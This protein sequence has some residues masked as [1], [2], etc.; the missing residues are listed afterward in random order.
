[1]N[2]QERSGV[3]AA[4]RRPNRGPAGAVIREASP[5]E[6]DRA[7]ADTGGE[8]P[9]ESLRESPRQA[10][11]RG[12]IAGIRT[13]TKEA[14]GGLDVRAAENLA[15][16]R[17]RQAGAGTAAPAATLAPAPRPAAQTPS[18]PVSDGL[19][20]WEREAPQPA[21]EPAS[22][23]AFQPDYYQGFSPE[24]RLAVAQMDALAILGRLPDGFELF[25]SGT[26]L[27]PE[28]VS[29]VMGLGF[30][31]GRGHVAYRGDNHYRLT[32]AGREAYR[33]GE[34]EHA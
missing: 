33:R 34:H 17:A 32:A 20:D 2:D 12:S 21:Q 31:I 6:L 3:G 22:L 11:G 25:V 8:V 27:G 5:E 7:F 18:Q 14:G 29:I 9:R 23:A 16:R 19:E 28:G 13:G 10:G 26:G 1:M 4:L 15:I 24:D 30:L